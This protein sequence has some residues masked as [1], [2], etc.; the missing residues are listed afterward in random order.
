MPADTLSFNSLLEEVI[1]TVP[2]RFGM[3]ALFLLTTAVLLFA[4]EDRSQ[5]RAI[6]ELRKRGATVRVE[7]KGDSK[8]VVAADLSGCVPAIT[9]E[10]LVHLRPLTQLR[11]LDL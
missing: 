8:T 11:T 7:E 2:F 6:A 3:S 4:Q 10:A 5:E 9:D 1:M